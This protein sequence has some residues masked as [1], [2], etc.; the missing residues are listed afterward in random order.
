[1][2]F[3]GSIFRNARIYLIRPT[4][5]PAFEVD[6]SS[7]KSGTLERID[8]TCAT[9]AHLAVDH[10]FAIR[11]DFV[12]AREYLGQGDVHGIRN[13]ADG[14]F[15]VLAHVDDLNVVAVVEA[16]LQFR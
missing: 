8:C 5:N 13:A 9:P 12:H 1:M 4:D 3:R 2:S 14:N 6:E 15:I 10:G 11:I 7:A 16:L